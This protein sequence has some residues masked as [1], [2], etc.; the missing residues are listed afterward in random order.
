M[1]YIRTLGYNFLVIQL[2]PTIVCEKLLFSFNLVIF[3]YSYFYFLVFLSFF[4]MIF[5]VMRLLKEHL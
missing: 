4:S 3:L 2:N 1:H 5:Q